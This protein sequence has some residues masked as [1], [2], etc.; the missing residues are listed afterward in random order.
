M[1]SINEWIE[2]QIELGRKP[3]E[4]KELLRESG[5]DPE[6]VDIVL[7]RKT[8]VKNSILKKLIPAVIVIS[9]VVALFVSFNIWN[10]D[11]EELTV[12][13]NIS[14]PIRPSSPSEV[15]ITVEGQHDDLEITEEIPVGLNLAGGHGGTFD[16]EVNEIQWKLEENKTEVGYIVVQSGLSTGVYE[17]MGNYSSDTGS[18]KINGEYELEVVW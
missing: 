13:R 3:N 5:Y 1:N 12:R 9:V 2:E 11:T 7:E 14:S 17:F 6:L 8:G 10:T 18:G 16:E 4:I 15:T